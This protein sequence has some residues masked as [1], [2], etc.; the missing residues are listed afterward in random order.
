LT[1]V[2]LEAG[3]LSQ[4]IYAGLIEAGFMTSLVETR[5]VNAALSAATVK[6][7]R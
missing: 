7:D 3:P 1:V 4:W 2:G 6:T 5:H